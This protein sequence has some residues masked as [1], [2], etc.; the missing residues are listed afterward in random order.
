MP[1]VREIVS[2]SLAHLGK[3][4]E[5]R[6]LTVG[7]WLEISESLPEDVSDQK[8]S[9]HMLAQSLRIDNKPIGWDAL[10]KLGVS[11]MQDALQSMTDIMGG[12]DAGE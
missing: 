4:I 12:S 2:P 1:R 5:V 11:D 8:R 3:R 9:L 10:L 6:E 7:E